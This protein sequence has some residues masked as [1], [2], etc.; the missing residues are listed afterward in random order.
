MENELPANKFSWKQAISEHPP[1]GVN[2]IIYDHHGVS[3][4]AFEVL[5]DRL[6]CVKSYDG[7]FC[8][9]E[10]DIYWL[11]TNATQEEK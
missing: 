11:D 2:L 1:F 4:A 10:P 6:F 7:I 3:R 9:A 8:P 5:N